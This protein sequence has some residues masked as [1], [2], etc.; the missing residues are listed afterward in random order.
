MFRKEGPLASPGRR[1]SFSVFAA[2]LFLGSI[3]VAASEPQAK[4]T[5]PILL[6]KTSTI[7]YYVSENGN[8]GG[9]KRI[10]LPTTGRQELGPSH[11]HGP[12]DKDSSQSTFGL[13]AAW[14]NIFK[15]RNNWVWFPMLKE[16]GHTS[17]APPRAL[18]KFLHGYFLVIYILIYG[19]FDIFI[20]VP[21]GQAGTAEPLLSTLEEQLKRTTK[22]SL[23][24]NHNFAV[25]FF[26]W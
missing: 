13:P 24:R 1:P 19:F 23:S 22:L 18:S 15:R 10:N 20:S 14:V 8:T 11:M 21:T 9:K 26:S 2:G 5:S 6:S 7:T 25:C 17:A 4:D 3:I 12:E 16:R